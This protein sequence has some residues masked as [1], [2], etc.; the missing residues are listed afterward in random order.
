MWYRRKIFGNFYFQFFT[1]ELYRSWTVF[2]TL[3]ISYV[4]IKRKYHYEVFF[5]ISLRF[6]FLDI[7]VIKLS[8]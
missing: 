2:P 3:E 4:G 8:Q 7:S 5:Y 6:L 1:R